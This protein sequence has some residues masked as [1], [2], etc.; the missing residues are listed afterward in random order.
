MTSAPGWQ[1]TLLR[2][3]RIDPSGGVEMLERPWV[4]H[5]YTRDGFASLVE[6]AGLQV[7]RSA[8]LDGTPAGPDT[9]DW[10]VSAGRP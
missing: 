7:I 8:A 4:L 10:V 6:D 9:T 2:Y 3:E 1:T 5:W